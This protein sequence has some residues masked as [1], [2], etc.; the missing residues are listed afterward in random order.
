MRC[1]VAVLSIPALIL[2]G[3]I[4]ATSSSASAAAAFLPRR[5]GS[6]MTPVNAHGEKQTNPTP[7]RFIAGLNPFTRKQDSS[8]S[9]K[10]IATDAEKPRSTIRRYLWS[11]ICLSYRESKI[12]EFLYAEAIILG[13]IIV[14]SACSALMMYPCKLSDTGDLPFTLPCAF[15]NLDEGCDR[16]TRDYLAS[17]SHYLLTLSHPSSSHGCNLRHGIHRYK[18][19]S[20]RGKDE[21]EAL[22]RVNKLSY[23]YRI[24]RPS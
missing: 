20:P 23:C 7:T 16:G 4:D 2:V 13:I 11:R 24:Q 8:A 19:V 6:K 5:H 14:T 21:R 9:S 22:G 3:A 15:E 17:C 10:P 12:Q 1:I 18:Y